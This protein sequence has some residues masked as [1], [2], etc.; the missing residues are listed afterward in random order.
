MRTAMQVAAFLAVFLFACTPCLLASELTILPEKSLRIPVPYGKTEGLEQLR[1]INPSAGRLDI[2]ATAGDIQHLPSGRKARMAF[3]RSGS[4][5]Y[6]VR[7]ALEAGTATDLAVRVSDVSVPGPFSGFIRIRTPEEA[8]DLEITADKTPPP[9]IELV[10]SR[11]GRIDLAAGSPEQSSFS[12]KLHNPEGGGIREIFVEASLVLNGQP[13][14]LSALVSPHGRIVLEQGESRRLTLTFDRIRKGSYE[15]ILSI[16]DLQNDHIRQE[17]MIGVKSPFMSWCDLLNS[18]N[19]KVIAL[20]FLGAIS[21]LLLTRLLPVASRRKVNREK[22]LDLRDRIRR[23]TAYELKLQHKFTVEINKAEALNDVTK[24]Y[25]PSASERLK[26][27]DDILEIIENHLEIREKI[28]SVYAHIDVKDV[29][30]FSMEERIRRILSEADLLLFQEQPEA[31]RERIKEAE[32]Q[33]EWDPQSKSSLDYYAKCLDS[34]EKIS[35]D[36][37]IHDSHLARL[38]RECQESIPGGLTSGAVSRTR[39]AEPEGVRDAFR[40]WDL[41]YSRV[42]IYHGFLKNLHK[43]LRKEQNAN[44]YG[45][46]QSELIELLQSNRYDD[47]RDAVDHCLSWQRG[48]TLSMI[49]DAL[50]ENEFDVF[51]QKDTVYLNETVTYAFH[52]Q[53]DA[54]NRSPLAD[55][56]I[57]S[58]DFGDLTGDTEG[59]K[60]I[61]YY[62][63]RGKFILARSWLKRKAVAAGIG[64]GPEWR[65]FGVGISVFTPDRCRIAHRPDAVTVSVKE[66]IESR[67]GSGISFPE[68]I[69]F[70]VTFIVSCVIAVATTYDEAYTFTSV[71]DFLAPFLLG[72]GLDI[73]RDTIRGAYEKVSARSS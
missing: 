43:D 3:H 30:P 73:G 48:V 26:T 38:V 20:V 21:S 7:I 28:S 40:T 70:L 44:V 49:R 46:L 34:L 39:S 16:Q 52:F 23:L 37:Q 13:G 56:F 54:L 11:D 55:R 10:D 64:S 9:P 33:L 36:T 12:I 4:D 22:I 42:L 51:P 27:V 69:G 19:H 47:L 67:F 35:K 25:T 14:L 57:Y 15:G 65:S 62:R 5:L 31:A 32:S 17:F 58:W 63:R 60:V 2:E 6:F 29:L 61:H 1:L 50:R 68:S 66:P 45:E 8:Y 53:D 18:R 24:P 72:F 59:R 71:K 41:Q